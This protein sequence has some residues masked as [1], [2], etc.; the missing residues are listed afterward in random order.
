MP[1]IISHM[2]VP[3]ALGL[4]LGRN[5]VSRSLLVVGVVASMLPDLD[6]LAFRLGIA[7]AD[8]LGHRG[9]SHSL[10]L[11]ALLGI[12]AALLARRLNSQRFAAF[13]FIF[14]ATASHGFLDMLTNGGLGVAYLWPF[15]DHR[16]FFS[17]QV[18]QVSPLSLKRFFGPAGLA[19]AK[20]ELF[21]VWSPAFFTFLI[22]LFL[23]R[24]I[25]PV[26]APYS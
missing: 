2:A 23:R 22:T 13:A 11:A 7:Y 3:L 1:T 4:G 5:T 26:Q 18:I 17:E 12:L 6:V 16:F 21:W 14:V 24:Q 20:S 9:F 15:S 10:A 19:V 25:A 8:Q